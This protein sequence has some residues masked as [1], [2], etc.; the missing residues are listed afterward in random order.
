MPIYIKGRKAK[1][2]WFRGQKIKEVWFRGQ[3]VYGEARRPARQATI[4]G[5]RSGFARY[6]WDITRVVGD[7]SIF[8][9]LTR[10]R[11]ALAVP[12]RLTAG[13]S[14]TWV[15]NGQYPSYGVGD[16]IPAGANSGP[17]LATFTFVE[18]V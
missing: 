18:V 4:T 3:K 8:S 1:E 17:Y 15:Y 16:I 2:V 13:E 5:V 10:D 6:A 7:K 12:A 11:I 9:Q 14:M